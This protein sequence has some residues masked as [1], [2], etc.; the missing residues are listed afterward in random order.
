MLSIVRYSLVLMFLPVMLFG[1]EKIKLSE[2]YRVK[3]TYYLGDK[4]FTGEVYEQDENGLIT[5]QGKLMDGQKEGFW[6]L[7]EFGDTLSIEYFSSG[8]KN[9]I[10]RKFYANN[11]INY[12]GMYANN[13]MNGNWR[14]YNDAGELTKTISYTNGK[15]QNEEY[16]AA[17]KHKKIS[18]G[19]QKGISQKMWGPMILLHF[20]PK[21]AI[22]TS[23]DFYANREGEEK[24][25]LNSLGSFNGT[26]GT[27]TG[28]TSEMTLIEGKRFQIGY[29][30]RFLSRW[31]SKLY[32]HISIGY[33]HFSNSA[34]H[35]QEVAPTT[36]ENYWYVENIETLL[37]PQWTASI[38][39][40]Y[41]ID[42]VFIGLGYDFQPN[43]LNLRLGL[44]F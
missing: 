29:A 2:L 1:Q 25:Q 8:I 24:A 36:G 21:H 22:M 44:N 19:L 16:T 38:G 14:I 35:Y 5:V 42:F 26:N 10:S 15:Y 11:V 34:I 33:N 23:M 9:G 18:F 4:P 37:T 6:T 40:M 30:F 31:E 17:F 28:L 20:G 3:K 43:G 13:K 41:H 39:V 7:F 32:G 12:S 27:L